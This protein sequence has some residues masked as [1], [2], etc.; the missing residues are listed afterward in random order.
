MANLAIVMK[1]PEPNREQSYPRT[2]T[3]QAGAESA[4]ADLDP[5]HR[6]QATREGSQRGYGR[7]AQAIGGNVMKLR[8][9]MEAGKAIGG[10][11]SESLARSLLSLN[12][13]IVALNLT[14]LALTAALL[15]NAAVAQSDS[16]IAVRRARLCANHPT[17]CGAPAGTPEPPDRNLGS[18][19]DRFLRMRPA[20]KKALK[21]A[22]P[23]IVQNGVVM[24]IPA[25]VRNAF[26]Q[27]ELRAETRK[28]TAQIQ[29]GRPMGVA[30][31]PVAPM[32]PTFAGGPALPHTL[33][34]TMDP[35]VAYR[36][37]AAMAGQPGAV[38]PDMLAVPMQ[39]PSSQVPQLG[40][41][42][43]P[44][45]QRLEFETCRAMGNCR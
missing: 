33:A 1:N 14:A 15:P 16:A 44:E 9:Y 37:P 43:S 24:V 8:V 39:P 18:F 36:N 27:A 25:P 21:K 32:I 6:K 2:V 20:L 30:G 40:S 11:E 17:V 13:R 23:Q 10:N 28:A 7:I 12:G 35:G 29:A 45:A 22:A 38:Y 42:I 41:Q 19:R 5:Q 34:M 26:Y 4:Q 3:L 31:Q